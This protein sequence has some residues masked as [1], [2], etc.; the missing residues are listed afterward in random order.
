MWKLPWCNPAPE[1]DSSPEAP[2]KQMN[3]GTTQVPNWL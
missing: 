1:N 3:L 2:L